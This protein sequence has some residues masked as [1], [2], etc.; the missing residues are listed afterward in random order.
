MLHIMYMK[1]HQ[2][3][4]FVQQLIKMNSVF[5]LYYLTLCLMW[6]VQRCGTCMLTVHY[7]QRSF[8]PTVVLCAV[9]Y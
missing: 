7:S 9:L 5:T 8:V 6:Q 3:I 1:R 2:N 4:D